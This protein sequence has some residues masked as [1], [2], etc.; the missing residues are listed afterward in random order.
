MMQSIL[1]QTGFWYF[2]I[3]AP[4]KLTDKQDLAPSGTGSVTLPSSETIG[5]ELTKL[6]LQ[7]HWFQ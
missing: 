7:M 3:S 5:T 4:W 2:L 6:K 1:T